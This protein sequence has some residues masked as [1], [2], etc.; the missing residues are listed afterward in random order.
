MK[1]TY[2]LPLAILAVAA[3]FLIS[4]FA[5]HSTISSEVFANANKLK[6]LRKSKDIRS[7]IDYK[8]EVKVLTTTTP[9]SDSKTNIEGIGPKIC[10][11]NTLSAQSCH[12]NFPSTCELHPRVIKYWDETTP[13][14]TSPLRKSSGLQNPNINDR[15]YVIMQPDLGG[16][17]NIRMA[18]EFGILFALVTGRIFVLPPPA[19]FY[20]LHMNK[21]WK[22]NFS[23][24]TDYLDFKRLTA[25][26]GLEVITMK[27]FLETVAS[28]NLLS[29][30]LP[31]NNTD[32]S[33]KLL[34]EYLESACYVRQWSPG[35]IFLGFNI[36]SRVNALGET[37]PVFGGFDSVTVDR[38]KLMRLDGVDRQMIPYD[39]EFHKHR[40]IYFPGNKNRYCCRC[41]CY[42]FFEYEFNT[43][44]FCTAFFGRT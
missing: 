12:L 19:V 5:L 41:C 40:V 44:I 6:I 11:K 4:K 24:Y 21:K 30:P 13:C 32:L 37:E 3:I 7:S 10:R 1:T 16:W 23:T 14:F 38:W 25:G 17:N 31:E 26:N 20:L 27:E 15:R 35:K 9:S 42:S 22:D 29:K 34:W 43:L 39:S 36:T 33:K 18:L 2:A 8:P 28:P